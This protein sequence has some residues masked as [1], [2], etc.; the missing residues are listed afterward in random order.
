MHLPEFVRGWGT[1]QFPD[2]APLV[3]WALVADTKENFSLRHRGTSGL[4][5]IENSSWRFFILNFTAFDIGNCRNKYHISKF[6][7]YLQSSG[8]KACTW[9]GL[10]IDLDISTDEKIWELKGWDGCWCVAEPSREETSTPKS[11]TKM[12]AVDEI[13]NIWWRTFSSFRTRRI[14]NSITKGCLLI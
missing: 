7:G 11:P 6:D 1:T 9:S 10:D 12:A 3:I 4:R 14:T 13:G 5:R 8:S 2:A